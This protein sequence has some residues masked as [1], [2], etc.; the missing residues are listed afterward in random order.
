[1]LRDIR[2][3][4]K[5]YIGAD[6]NHKTKYN[7]HRTRE[8]NDAKL[9]MK[10]VRKHYLVSGY[11][12]RWSCAKTVK[13]IEKSSNEWEVGILVI[14]DLVQEELEWEDYQKIGSYLCND[15]CDSNKDQEPIAFEIAP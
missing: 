11:Q 10:I 12:V 3:Q 15:H 13:E 4:E 6:G 2:S 5:L 1:M 8:K 9:C 7:E 14:D